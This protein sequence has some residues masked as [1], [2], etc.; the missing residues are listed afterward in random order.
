MKDKV[1]DMVYVMVMIG[2]AIVMLAVA[3]E[4]SLAYILCFL[5]GILVG[6]LLPKKQKQ[7]GI[8]WK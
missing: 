1:K 3:M 4:E 5:Y 2:F 8:R 6:A 7:E